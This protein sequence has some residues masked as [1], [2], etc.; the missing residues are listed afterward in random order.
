MNPTIEQIRE[1][2]LRTG[3]GLLEVRNAFRQ[4]NSFEEAIP[5]LQKQGHAVVE[6][7]QTKTAGV[8]RIQTYTHIN[9]KYA[10]L[11]EFQTETDFA[12]N[13]DLFKSMMYDVCMHVAAS[14]RI[15]NNP[16]EGEYSGIES[17]PFVKD[18]SKTVGDVLSEVSAALKEKVQISYVFARRVTS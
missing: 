17:E 5:Y 13:S 18:P 11:V 1:I 12:A 7:R 6:Q 9:G 8:R 15:V 4:V 14:P 2:R 16:G 10:S 3:L